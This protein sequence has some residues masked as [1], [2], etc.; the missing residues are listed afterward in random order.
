MNNVGTNYLQSEYEELLKE[1]SAREL[2]EAE[3][4][5]FINKNYGFEASRIEIH[6]DAIVAYFNKK[7]HH[8]TPVWTPT[9]LHPRRAGRHSSHPYRL[10]PSRWKAARS[11]GTDHATECPS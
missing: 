8:G 6:M 4:K 7:E 9:A 5:M 3:A 1:P 10:R 2:T 11:P